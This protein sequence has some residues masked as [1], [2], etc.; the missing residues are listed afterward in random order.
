MIEWLKSLFRSYPELKTGI[1]NLKSGTA[2]RGVI[3]ARAGDWYILRQAA[4][5]PDNKP[6][7]GEVLIKKSDIDFI[8]IVL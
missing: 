2:M 5:L 1:V 4:L 3:Y 8:Q 6:I 7:D